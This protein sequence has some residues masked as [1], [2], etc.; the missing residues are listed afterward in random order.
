MKLEFPE[1][2]F[3]K[4]SNIKFHKNVFIGSQVVPYEWTDRQMDLVVVVCNFANVPKSQ[5]CVHHL[6]HTIALT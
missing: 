6:N 4:S 3:K 1:Q 2:I 5:Q